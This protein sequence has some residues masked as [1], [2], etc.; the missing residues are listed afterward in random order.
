MRIS[1]KIG[2]AGILLLITYSFLEANTDA[3]FEVRSYQSVNGTCTSQVNDKPY[4]LARFK[5]NKQRSEV[6]QTS[7]DIGYEGIANLLHD[8][9]KVF[10]NK[11]WKCG[12][13]VFVIEGLEYTHASWELID[14]RTLEY[15][16]LERRVLSSGE[17]QYRGCEINFGKA[18]LLT[19]LMF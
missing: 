13:R 16:P 10:D 15:S 18:G 17:L 5:L 14:G 7:K 2:V 4:M 19:A 12:G 1:I 3:V 11:N 8:D 9:C 6:L